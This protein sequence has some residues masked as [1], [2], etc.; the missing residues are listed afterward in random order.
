M[1]DYYTASIPDEQQRFETETVDRNVR[2]FRRPIKNT[3]CKVVAESEGSN[4][5]LDMPPDLRNRGLEDTLIACIDNLKGWWLQ[6]M[7]HLFP[8]AKTQTGNKKNST[9]R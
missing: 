6:D 1:D 3:F 4:F 5:W 8:E 9:M 2:S 7:R